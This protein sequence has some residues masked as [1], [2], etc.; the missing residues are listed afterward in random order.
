VT[1]P[2]AAA[3]RDWITARLDP[4]TLDG[5]SSHPVRGDLDLYI[6]NPS[7]RPAPLKAAAV[8]FGLVERPAGLSV[9]FTR[10]ADTLRSHTGQVALPGGRC[11]PGETPWA[12][13]LREAEEEVG[14]DP[15]HVT[16]AGLSTPYRTGTGYH[17]I[18]VVG[19]VKPPFALTA[20]PDQK[21]WLMADLDGRLDSARE[22]LLRFASPVIYMRR[23]ATHDTR[24]GDTAIAAGDKV[25]MYFGAA[26][27][28]PARF[29]DPDR[30]DLA[31]TPN[32]HIAFGG[33]PHVCLGQ[34][35]AR[36]EI[37]AI[38]RE[39]LTRMEGFEI[40][41][42]PEWLAS[43]FISGPKSMPVRFRPGPRL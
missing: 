42:P 16:L 34:H 39:V 25:V 2:A 20:N 23:T 24:I 10:R 19:F 29:A 27:R 31:R 21:A 9:I 40:P 4:L 22:E 43:T 18:P 8:L 13:A 32:E 3:Q 12:A 33:G 37:D 1:S 11:D 35:L 15:S 41:Q 30:L 28:D 17:V 26:N 7:H 14:L 6:D 5:V 38:L 36:L